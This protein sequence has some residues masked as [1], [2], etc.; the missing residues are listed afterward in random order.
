MLTFVICF[1]CGKESEGL[2]IS[3]KNVKNNHNA[4]AS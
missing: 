1:D 2:I 4:E 3:K